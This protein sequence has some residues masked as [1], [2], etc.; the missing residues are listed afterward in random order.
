MYESF[1][2]CID[3]NTSSINNDRIDTIQI[4]FCCILINWVLTSLILHSSMI[5]AVK[6]VA[7]EVFE[8]LKYCPSVV[9]LLISK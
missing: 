1:V 8:L 7:L 2:V 6:S 4:V 5:K 9:K 3:H